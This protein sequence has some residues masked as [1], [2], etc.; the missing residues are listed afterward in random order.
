VPRRRG[1][2]DAVATIRDVDP[3]AADTL[4]YIEDL[5]V[6]IRGEARSLGNRI[7]AG[8]TTRPIGDRSGGEA[9][10]GPLEAVDRLDEIRVGLQRVVARRPIE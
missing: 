1:E 3:S 4:A 6:R 8:A 9:F 10:G 7:V 5:V 2:S